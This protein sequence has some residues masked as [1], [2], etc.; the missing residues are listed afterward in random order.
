MAF[1]INFISIHV[2]S[3][4]DK[5]F[6]II[7]FYNNLPRC[8]YSNKIN[9]RLNSKYRRFKL[10]MVEDFR[11]TAKKKD[12]LEDQYYGSRYLFQSFFKLPTENQFVRWKNF[13]SFSAVINKLMICTICIGMR[14]LLA[15]G[16][17]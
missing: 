16:V 1:Y 14:R 13:R 11:Q 7:F 3:S 8:R 2:E 15:T 9:F 6:L 5:F 17:A 12:D 10:K 4:T